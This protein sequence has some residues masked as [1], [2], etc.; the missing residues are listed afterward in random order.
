[1][2][3]W[4]LNRI[5]IKINIFRI[6]TKIMS[7]ITFFSNADLWDKKNLLTDE[8]NYI[9][10]ALI[11]IDKNC[12]IICRDY[13]NYNYKNIHKFLPWGNLFPKIG[14]GIKIYILKKLNVWKIIEEMS[15]YRASIKLKNEKIIGYCFAHVPKCQ[16]KIKKNNWIFIFHS[17]SAHPLYN[18]NLTKKFGVENAINIEEYLKYIKKCWRLHNNSL[19]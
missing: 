15:D 19:D 4:A 16:K 14:M 13:K 11:K 2:I 10:K 17:W 7:K 5:C 6:C 12:Q 1:M 9:I 3:L 18:L 8:A